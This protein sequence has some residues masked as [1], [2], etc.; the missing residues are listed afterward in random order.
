MWSVNGELT[1]EIS[2]NAACVSSQTLHL[3]VAKRMGATWYKV[4]VLWV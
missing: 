3:L 1:L 4:Y 2:G